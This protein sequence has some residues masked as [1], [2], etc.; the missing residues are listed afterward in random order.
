MSTKS[1]SHE[2]RGQAATRKLEMAENKKNIAAQLAE[3]QKIADKALVSKM[4][5]LRALRLARDAVLA[6]EA[7]AAA[8][9][10][11]LTKPAPKKKRAVKE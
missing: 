2:E 5:G 9:L 7:E 6:E 11:A 1:K 8:A 3:E 4:A 10:K